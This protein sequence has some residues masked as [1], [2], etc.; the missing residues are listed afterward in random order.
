MLE[1]FQRVKLIRKDLVET[2]RG[3][4]VKLTKGQAGVIVE[5]HQIA[6]LPVGYSVEF[7]DD[8]GETVAIS[9]LEEK[10]LEPV[11]VRLQNKSQDVA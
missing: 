8:D 7:F 11:E 6:G 9:T 5:I 2:L 3:E 10:D 1:Q 4:T